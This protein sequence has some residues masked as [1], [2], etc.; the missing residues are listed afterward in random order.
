MKE[1]IIKLCSE[2]VERLQKRG[3]TISLAESCTGGLAAA[4]LVSVPSAS[5]VFNS[6]FVT[7][8]NSSKCKYLGVNEETIAS[9]GVV[10]E[11]VA[12]QMARGTALANCAE[13]GVG[14]TGI[15][16]PTGGTNE[17]PVGTVCFGFYIDGELFCETA[18]FENMDRNSVREASCEFV[19]SQLCKML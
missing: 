8:S 11:A 12:C 10:S 16:G 19:F 7:Y 15:A 5:C 1:E 18:H 17:K 14:I 3:L 6:S 2:L 9:V 13:V 4:Y